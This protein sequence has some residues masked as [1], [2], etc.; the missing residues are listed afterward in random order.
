MPRAE[1]VAGIHTTPAVIPEDGKDASRD[2]GA[3]MTKQKSARHLDRSESASGVERP[4]GSNSDV[5]GYSTGFLAALPMT[6]NLIR[7]VIP[8][9]VEE[10]SDGTESRNPA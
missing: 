3:G 5:T 9:G 8:S 4:R 2:F 6:L 7:A 1:A 10:C